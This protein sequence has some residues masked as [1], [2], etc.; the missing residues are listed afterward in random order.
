MV[1][2]GY[3]TA[4]IRESLLEMLFNVGDIFAEACRRLEPLGVI[5]PF[6]LQLMVTKDLDVVVFDVALRIDGGT[7][8]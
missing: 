5:G 3:R 1:E 4:T 2:V 7:N 8:I 6:T